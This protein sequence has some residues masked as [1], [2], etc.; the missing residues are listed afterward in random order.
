MSL[1]V[2]AIIGQ[3]NVGKSTLFN[4]LT[5]SQQALVHDMPGVTRDRHFGQGKV[6]PYPYIVIDTG[7]ISGR[8]EGM[9]EMMAGQ[10][11]LAVMQADI[12]L[13]MVDATAGVT[14]NDLFISKALR[15]VSKPIFCV[16]NKTD[17]RD[18]II[19]MSDFYSFGFKYMHAIA[20]SHNRGIKPLMDAVFEVVIELS[21]EPQEEQ[22]QAGIKMAI[23]GR[24]NVGKST[25]VNRML[26]EDRVIVYDEPGTTRDSIYIP[27]V[28]NEQVYTIIDTAGVRRRKNIDEAV[29]KFSVVKTL[30][31]IEDAHVVIYMID[32][33]QA[34]TDQDLSLL[35]FI[36]EAGR[37][38]VVAINKW[39]HLT[40][41]QRTIIKT[42]IDRQLEFVSFAKLYFISA[43]HGSG[44]GLLFDAVNQAYESATRKLSTARLTRMLQKAIEQHQP[45]M[46]HGRR[47]KLRYAHAGGHIPQ[48]VVI[49]GNQTDDVPISYQ[50]F[51]SHYFR[52]ELK[53]V[54]SPLRLIFNTTENP[55]AG[56]RNTLTPR[57]MRKRTRLKKFIRKMKKK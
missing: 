54:G 40:D 45:P 39:D 6:G 14:P 8:E 31:A 33:Q 50:R 19:A 46:V 28:R 27:F 34:V 16:V 9:D 11:W 36:V 5:R 2:I 53:L 52:D 37:S 30:Q 1:P 56:R 15:K 29:E 35:G 48:T 26:G 49:H 57:Q 47:I 20:A 41:D 32:G 44:V 17:G 38:L 43:L 23:V 51:L 55:F 22:P 10:S 7:G 25:L 4:C 42:G 21:G 13:F 18:E 12:I 24:P 3:P